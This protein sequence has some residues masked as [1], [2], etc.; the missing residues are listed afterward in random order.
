M[1]AHP[2]QTAQARGAALPMRMS[3]MTMNRWELR[4]SSWNS[5]KASGVGGC[6]GG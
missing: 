2:R 5:S 1:I 6:N 4:M 3:G